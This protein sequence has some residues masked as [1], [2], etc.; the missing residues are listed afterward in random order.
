M[1][2]EIASKSV[3]RIAFIALALVVC[4]WRV[5]RAQD[6]EEIAPVDRDVST[7]VDDRSPIDAPDQ[8]TAGADTKPAT[9]LAT[10]ADPPVIDLQSR[11]KDIKVKS[12]PAGDVVRVHTDEGTIDLTPAQFVRAV[13]ATQTRVHDGGLFYRLFNISKPASFVWISVGLLGQVMFTFRMILQWWASEKHKRSIV[14]VGFW[15]G[16]LFGGVMLFAYFCWRKDVVGIIGQS[17]GVFIYA[18]NLMLIYSG[19][20]IESEGARTVETPNESDG[21][22]DE[23]IVSMRAT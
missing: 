4:G 8:Q 12:T 10:G 9:S 19:K 6:F 22:D 20:R 18:R 7:L 15:W 23:H 21:D 5:V 14:P 11:I 1:G 13:G 16:S 2:A 3:A 17:T